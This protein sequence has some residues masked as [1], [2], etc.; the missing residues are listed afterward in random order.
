MMFA[1]PLARRLLA[2][3]CCR[4]LHVKPSHPLAP[5][6]GW[7]FF[8]FPMWSTHWDYEDEVEV[9]LDISM[10]HGGNGFETQKGTFDTHG[11]YLTALP[12]AILRS[13]ARRLSPL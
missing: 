9:T 4:L 2:R 13:N 3:C 7:D 5:E 12:W 1:C 8:L 10:P 6:P 11:G